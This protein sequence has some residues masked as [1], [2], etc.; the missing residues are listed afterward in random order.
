MTV[1]KRANDWLAGITKLS[2]LTTWK[3]ER[4]DGVYR[5]GR[6]YDWK[7]L[8]YWVKTH[9]AAGRDADI[10]SVWYAILGIEKAN[11]NRCIR[12]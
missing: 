10:C 3:M 7:D 4:V 1:G 9:Y 12:L 11:R 2:V 5:A 8:D 6:A